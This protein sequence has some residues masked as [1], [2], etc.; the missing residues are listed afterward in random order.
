MGLRRYG[1]LSDKGV[2]AR[3]RFLADTQLGYPGADL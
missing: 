2:T 3:T 1:D